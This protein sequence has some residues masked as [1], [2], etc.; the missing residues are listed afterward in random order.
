MVLFSFTLFNGFIRTV[1]GM[2]AL[3]CRVQTNIHVYKTSAV[4]RQLRIHDNNIVLKIV[5]HCFKSSIV[6]A[7]GPLTINDL[8]I[9]WNPSLI[10]LYEYHVF[11]GTTVSTVLYYCTTTTTVLYCSFIVSRRA[12]LLIL[13][14]ST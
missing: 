5:S 7:F 14:I 4:L 9:S 6:L 13:L 2:V 1:L 11:W 3:N 10:S 8:F 12:I